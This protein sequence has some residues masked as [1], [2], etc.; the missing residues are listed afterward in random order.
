MRL[1]KFVGGLDTAF[2]H[3]MIIFVTCLVN[4]TTTEWTE[5]LT[6]ANARKQRV[7]FVAP[8]VCVQ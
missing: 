3:N 5:P 2:R 8:S 6:T 7:R 1:T 4:K